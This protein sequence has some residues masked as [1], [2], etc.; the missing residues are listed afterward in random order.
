[1]RKFWKM[2]EDNKKIEE[3]F[4]KNQAEL[5]YKQQRLNK[6]KENLE[7]EEAILEEKQRFGRVRTSAMSYMRERY[8]INVADRAMWRINKRFKSKQVSR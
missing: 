1:M 2:E 3:W 7:C 6:I 8:G 5:D 4:N